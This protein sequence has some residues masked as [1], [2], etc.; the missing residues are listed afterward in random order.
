MMSKRLFLKS[1]REDMR[2]KVWMLA[3]SVLGNFL[4]LPVLWLLAYSDGELWRLR[5]ALD[6]VGAQERLAGQM[7]EFFSEGLLLAAGIVAIIGA[8]IVGLEGFRFLQQKSMVDTYHSLPVSR[9]CLFGVKYVNGLLIWLVPYLLCMVLALV[10]A[11]VTLARMGG[12][13]G[14]PALIAEAAQNTLVLV[15]AFLLVYHTVLLATMLTGNMLNTLAVTGMLGFG[16]ILAYGLVQGFMASYFHTYYGHMKGMT[17]AVYAS[18][19]AMPFIL[20]DVRMNGNSQVSGGLLST[21]LI[22]LAVAL[23]LGVLAWL[24]YWRRPSERA[25]QGLGLWWIAGPLRLF[26]GILSGMGGWLFM[27]FLVDSNVSRTAWS[28][29]GALLTGMLVYGVLDVI[30]SMEFKAFFRHRWGM[31]ASALLLLLICFGFQGDWMGYDRYLPAQE[32]IQE[33]SIACRS[34][35]STYNNYNAMQV[36]DGVK[37]TDAAQIHAFLERGTENV[38]G[39]FNGTQDSWEEIYQGDYF[40]RDAF[41]VRVVLKNGRS[42][43]RI[44]HFY[45]WDEDVVL[46]LLC[47]REYADGAYR[48]SEELIESCVGMRLSSG[49]GGDGGIA[50]ERDRTVLRELA[51]AYNQDLLEQPQTIILS[52]GRLLGQIAILQGQNGYSRNMDILDSMTHTLAALE[53]NGIHIFNQPT[54]ATEVE[55][56]TFQVDV[57]SYWYEGGGAVNA[58]ERS[59]RIHFGVYPEGM[60]RVSGEDTNPGPG[61]SSDED[62]GMS[63]PETVTE[64]EYSFTVTDPAEIEELLPLMQYSDS[65]NNMGVFV[66]GLVED[67]Y[68]LERGGVEWRACLRSGALP[69]KYILRFVEEARNASPD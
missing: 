37:L 1:M 27:S 67:V 48:L 11:A 10:F 2:H 46:P 68:I 64:G 32:Q 24:A 55:S 7:A 57:S 50:V 41:R 23:A 59:I 49:V 3:L 34:Y 13:D 69:E 16:S 17:S 62:D 14:I 4:A 51:E 40:S 18:P 29:F 56:I 33:M 31:A 36:M 63:I 52:Q 42:Y 30:F 38:Q 60:P 47:S 12:T 44:Y 43:Y 54:E 28:V 6:G 8:V 39:R 9:S 26:A 15:I 21:E 53:K 35:T 45:Q 25:G 5:A 58:V 65:R 20:L 61:A 66:D 22:C 19:L